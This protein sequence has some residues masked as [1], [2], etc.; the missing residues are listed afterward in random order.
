MIVK[1]YKLGYINKI[2]SFF[3]VPKGEV[4]TPEPPGCTSVL[5]V[6]EYRYYKYT[7][8]QTYSNITFP[9]KTFNNSTCTLYITPIICTKSTFQ[10]FIRLIST[11]LSVCYGSIFSNIL[12]T[13]LPA[14]V[15]FCLMYLKLFQIKCFQKINCLG[16]NICITK[17]FYAEQFHMIF[18]SFGLFA[19]SATL[20][21]FQNWQCLE[22]CLNF[23]H[24][25]TAALAAPVVLFCTW[26]YCTISQ[27]GIAARTQTLTQGS[28]GKEKIM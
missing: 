3:F 22:H 12:W 23:Q 1:C 20:G 16:Q 19:V 14:V 28:E 13:V 9:F 15:S 5:L 4:S 27:A 26:I 11:H 7:R 24:E 2:K 10:Y 6:I 21:R 25:N 18:N 17:F 8:V